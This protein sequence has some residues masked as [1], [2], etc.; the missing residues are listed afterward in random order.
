MVKPNLN[1][2][3]V[4]AT[5]AA[6]RSFSKAATELGVVPSSLSHTMRT[7]EETLGVRLLHRTTRSVSLTEA[8]ERLFARIVPAFKDVDLGLAEIDTFR[9]SP[10]GTVRIN[11]PEVAARV[12][13]AHVVPVVLA[14]Y[15]DVA[16]DIAVEGR[17]IDV[18]D[19]G[20][21]AGVRLGESLAQ[22]MVAVRF[23]GNA[24]FVAVASPAYLERHGMPKV[25]DDLHRHACIRHRFASG[26]IYRWEFE[27]H[28]QPLA[29]DVPGR[30]TL[31]QTSLMVEAAVQGL[32]IAFVPTHAIQ[33]ELDAGQLV[34]V[35]GDWCPS[36]P[37]M[38]LY[39]PS[40]RQVPSSLRAFIEVMKEVLP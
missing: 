32:G 11:A 9:T 14:R 33:A 5:I 10:N 26:K 21:D 38:F 23:A 24:R 39:Y 25:P 22:D 19:A 8:G 3:K 36:I 35:L 16:V 6:C 17:L 4:F 30:V 15:P 18:V 1:D 40:H 34:T 31:D 29:I 37:G 28:G 20:F 27:R 13:L 12:L 7:L 2:L